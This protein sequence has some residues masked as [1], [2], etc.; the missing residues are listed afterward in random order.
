MHGKNGHLFT[1]PC[2][3]RP[4][5]RAQG[6]EVTYWRRDDRILLFV[7]RPGRTEIELRFSAP[8][9]EVVDE[10]TGA[11]LGEGDRFRLTFEDAAFLSLTRP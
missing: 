9:R 8:V 1:S 7:L 6:A 5:V 3:V 11:K 10:R 4:W 2:G